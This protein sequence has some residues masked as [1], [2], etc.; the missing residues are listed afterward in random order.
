MPDT[1]TDVGAQQINIIGYDNLDITLH[2][3]A[4]ETVSGN[5][6]DFDFQDIRTGFLV[7]DVTALTTPGAGADD[8]SFFFEAKDT[9]SG[10]Y[11]THATF[12]ITEAT[13]PETEV[14]FCDDTTAALPTAPTNFT[15][16][17]AHPI[18]ANTY[19]F[20][21]VPATSGPTWTFSASFLSKIQ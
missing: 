8:I 11:F 17:Q 20:R 3:S 5:S 14:V 6:V 13:I 16:L 18:N 7:V 15:Y 12:T 10:K 1:I 4:G 19:R 9:V 21:W 2:A